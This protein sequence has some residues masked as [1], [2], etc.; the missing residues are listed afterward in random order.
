MNIAVNQQN[1]VD[2]FSGILCSVVSSKIPRWGYN[3]N[4]SLNDYSGHIQKD[5]LK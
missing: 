2:I 4:S 3:M 1:A 5:K